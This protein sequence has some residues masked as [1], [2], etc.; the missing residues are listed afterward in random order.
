MFDIPW[1]KPLVFI[2]GGILGGMVLGWVVGKIIARIKYPDPN[3][4]RLYSGKQLLVVMG[5][6][7]VSIGLILFAVLYQPKAE[8][9]SDPSL[10]P[11]AGGEMLPG[12]GEVLPT[13][14]E[15]TE[16]GEPA[17]DAEG[18]GEEEKPAPDVGASEEE[19]EPAEA[20]VADTPVAMAP[21]GAGAVAVLR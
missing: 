3:K 12:E 19:E 7:V 2:F 18:S 4:T 11:A 17:A 6:V 15:L 10:D 14:G 8:D 9:P 20:P 5:V 16:G 21:A 13:D 1:V